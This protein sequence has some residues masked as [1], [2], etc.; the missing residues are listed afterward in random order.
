MMATITK[1]IESFKIDCKQM[2]L[3]EGVKDMDTHSTIFT[4]ACAIFSF[5]QKSMKIISQ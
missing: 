2:S 4:K 1:S 5:H 3:K